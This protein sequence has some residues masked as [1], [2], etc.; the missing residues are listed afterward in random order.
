MGFSLW[1]ILKVVVLCT[2]AL[3]ILNEGLLKKC[4]SFA[5]SQPVAGRF[6]GECGTRKAASI[7]RVPSLFPVRRLPS[8][9]VLSFLLVAFLFRFFCPCYLS[10]FVL[11]RWPQRVQPG[12]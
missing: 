5:Y 2:N 9:F 1:S 11:D 10:A 12:P 7:Q 3:A 8:L 6:P 4:A